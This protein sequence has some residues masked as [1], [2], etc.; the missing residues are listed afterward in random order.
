[1]VDDLDL[2]HAGAEARERVD[3]PLQAIVGLDDLLGRPL[4]K[5]VR[6]VIE[7]QRTRSCDMQHVEAAV[8]EDSVVLERERPLGPGA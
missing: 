7:H 3:E 1:M 4:R 6:L 8:Q 2:V 5:R